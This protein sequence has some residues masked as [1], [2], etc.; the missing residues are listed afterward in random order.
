MKKKTKTTDD[1][2]Q[3]SFVNS[4]SKSVMDRD[5]ILAW[6]GQRWIP[7][8]RGQVRELIPDKERWKR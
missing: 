3:K 4:I 2:K 5:A 6:Q 7:K 8:V 1:K